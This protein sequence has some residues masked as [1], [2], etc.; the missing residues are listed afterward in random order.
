MPLNLDLNKAPI[1]FL[2]DES[3][4]ASMNPSSSLITSNNQTDQK[5]FDDENRT[6]SMN[7]SPNLVT[8]YNTSPLEFFDNENITTFMNPSSSSVMNDLFSDEDDSEEDEESAQIISQEELLI[9]RLQK[10]LHVQLE[11]VA[12]FKEKP[13]QKLTFLS[14]SSKLP[15][16]SSLPEI[17]EKPESDRGRSVNKSTL[18]RIG[19]AFAFGAEKLKEILNL[20]GESMGGALE[21]FFMNTLNRNGKGQ[22]PDID[23]PVPAFGTGRSEEPV[24]VGDCDSF[25]GGLQ[26]AQM[27]TSQKSERKEIEEVPSETDMNE[28]ISKSFELSNEDFPLLLSIGNRNSSASQQSEPH[29]NSSSPQ[30]FLE[31]GTRSIPQPATEMSLGRKSQKE[32]SSA[33]TPVVPSLAVETKGKCARVE[34]K[35]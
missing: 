31:F 16:L 22:M 4:T 14:L 32:D 15:P 21:V 11:V 35:T 12:N 13:I 9:I 33:T 19:Y 30:M 6:T 2:D 25:Y 23:V 7:H 17:V 18:H 29:H 34:E 20:P 26:H 8:D 5:F 24:L 3:S 27:Y 10:W 28:N 1:E